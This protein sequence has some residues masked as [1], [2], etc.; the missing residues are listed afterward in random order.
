LIKQHGGSAE[1]L[2][3]DLEQRDRDKVLVRFSQSSCSVLVATDVAA[4]G[5]DIAD[6]SMVVNYDVPRDPEIY[7]HRVGRTGRAGK[8]GL[9][10]SIYSD[11]EGYKVEAI[12]DYRKQPT[13]YLD[14]DMLDANKPLPLP[15]WVSLEIAGG[16]KD[17]IRPGDLLGALTANQLLTGKAVGNIAIFDRVSYVAVAEADA[18]LALKQLTAG[19]VKGRKVMARIA[20]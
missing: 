7:I 2:H 9:A 17:K 3:G 13:V 12:E 5:I 18:K 4:R 16:R 8:S 6:L 19:K 10:L 15:A 14:P 11:S 1:A 20:K